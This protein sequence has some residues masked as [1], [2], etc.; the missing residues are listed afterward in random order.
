MFAIHARPVDAKEE[1][2]FSLCDFCLHPE[3]CDIC[4]VSLGAASPLALGPAP[5]STVEAR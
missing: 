3:C 4:P 2:V 1:P 5:I